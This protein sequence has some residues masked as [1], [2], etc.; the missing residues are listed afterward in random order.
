VSILINI[1]LIYGAYLFA[2]PLLNKRFQTWLIVREILNQFNN[3]ISD[4]KKLPVTLNLEYL[5]KEIIEKVED[6]LLSKGYKISNKNNSITI[7]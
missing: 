3:S 4:W 5:S 1:G 7:E 2:N 6:K